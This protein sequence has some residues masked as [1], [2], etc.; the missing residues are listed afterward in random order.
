M[1]TRYLFAAIVLILT[2]SIGMMTAQRAEA[3]IATHECSFCHDFHGAI[4]NTG[5]LKYSSTEVLCLSCHSTIVGSTEAAAV[6]NPQG[7]ASNQQGYIT[8]RECHNPHDNVDGNIK[9]V[10]YKFDP[11]TLQRFTVPTIREELTTSLP[12]SPVYKEVTF[13]TMTEPADYYRN[14][15]KGVCEICHTSNHLVGKDC[16]NCHNHKNDFGG[17]VDPAEGFPP[18][19]PE[20]TYCH[21]GTGTDDGGLFS[22]DAYNVGPSSNHIKT[23]GSASFFKCTDCH[24]SHSETPDV[25]IPNNPIVGIFYTANGESG[26][27]LGGAATSG[28]TEAEICWNCHGGGQSEWSGQAHLGYGVST[29]NWATAVFDAP[30]GG[31]LTDVIPDRP[32]RSIHTANDI[33]MPDA[34]LSEVENDVRSSSVADN[35]DSNGE[36]PSSTWVT[37][38]NANDEV[39]EKVKYIRCSYCHDVHD[40]YGPDKGVTISSN[41]PNAPTF[42]N[43]YLR[44]TWLPNPYVGR[45]SAGTT[46]QPEVPPW[47]SGRTYYGPSSGNYNSN[48]SNTPVDPD[49]GN[50]WG[51]KENG[52]GS[53]WVNFPRL[54]STS[55][56]STYEGGFFIDQNSG[57]PNSSF[58]DT[59]TPSNEV[60]DTAGLC[61]LCHGSDTDN[62]D[63]YS[64]SSL[65][66]TATNGHSNSTLGG[67]GSGA[68]I[69][70]GRRDLP[71]TTEFSMQNQVSVD[72]Q[73]SGE[74]RWGSSDGYHPPG[75]PSAARDVLP[76]GD[77][78]EDLR[79]DNNNDWAPPFNSGWYGGTA[80]T[81]PRQGVGDYDNWFFSG[82]IGSHN[83]PSGRAHDFSCSKCHS[84]HA[85]GLPALLI[86]NCLDTDVATWTA[87]GRNNSGTNVTVGPTATNTWAR[88]ASGNCHRK[89]WWSDTA[90]G[91]DPANN[92]GWHKL[93]PGQ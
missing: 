27:G 33:D 31:S 36:L 16:I 29:E 77:G 88:R 67:S 57:W 73:G 68:D 43:T 65:W 69:F 90:N 19:S 47:D 78:F 10:G 17:T 51:H 39:L 26:I 70:N 54:Y 35:V 64:G 23:S 24:P 58:I 14:D 13:A 46:N 5:L 41:N 30:N 81:K 59:A 75:L 53:N 9:L 42:T 4:S 37:T 7:L 61:V 28:T 86:T 83:G 6:H 66:R 52:S 38:S 79:I 18:V 50:N 44:G 91:N 45:D 2:V 48:G 85:S 74:R 1:R 40:T 76:F 49:N 21:N 63:Y 15:G 22:Y 72:Y 71:D 34:S 87:T 80:G 8:C 60:T 25:V 62:M 56:Y 32:T 82:Q 12:G 93:A 3:L 89:E 11:S 20:C 84:P 92:T 55:V